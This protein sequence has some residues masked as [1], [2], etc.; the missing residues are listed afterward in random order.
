MEQYIRDKYERKLFMS[1]D[2]AASFSRGAAA[3]GPAAVSTSRTAVA[4]S[5]SIGQGATG[6][7]RYPL[8]MGSLQ[9]MGFT[10]AAANQAALLST[11]GNLQQAI[12]A[13]LS[14][15][16][17]KPKSREQEYAPSSSSQ[18]KTNAADDL[19]DVF[20]IAAH[21]P[22][23]ST[24]AKSSSA[25]LR[26]ADQSVSNRSNSILDMDFPPPPTKEYQQPANDVSDE[27]EEFE[28]A[29]DFKSSMNQLP[30]R[31]ESLE[32]RRSSVTDHH[33]GF[34]EIKPSSQVKPVSSAD[35]TLGGNPW[36]SF[37]DGSGAANGTGDAFDDIDPFRGYNPTT[38]STPR[39][40]NHNN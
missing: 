35:T 20:G 32:P 26:S 1:A 24:A 23:I 22:L 18:R 15:K 34:G 28:S 11:S 21:P 9:E 5:G 7:E 36:A 10:D 16:A 12:E 25:S 8:Q 6:A 19:A 27:F 39:D 31:T 3:G 33:D 14:G 2:N 13:L 40:Q 29:T 4:R 38:S 30:S 17:G 37:T